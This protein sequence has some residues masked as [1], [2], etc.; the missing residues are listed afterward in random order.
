MDGKAVVGGQCLENQYGIPASGWV[1]CVRVWVWV[2]G[3]DGTVD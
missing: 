3:V 1:C 2:C